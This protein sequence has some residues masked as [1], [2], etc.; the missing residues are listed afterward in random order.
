MLLS[1]PGARVAFGGAEL[2]GGNHSIPKCYGAIQPTAVFVPL[3]EMLS[4]SDH[5]A[6]ATTE[7]FG[8]LQVD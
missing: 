1:I 5:F 6:A 8:P 7:I 2:E 4:S 3:K